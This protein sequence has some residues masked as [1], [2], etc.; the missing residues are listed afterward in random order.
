MLALGF[1]ISNEYIRRNRTLYI[2][3]ASSKYATVKIPGVG[4]FTNLKGRD[5]VP[6][7]EGRYQAVISG[8]VQQTVDFEISSGYWGRWFGDPVWVLNIG[9]ESILE[10]VHAHYRAEDP[11]P[12]DY[13]FLYGESFHRFPEVT[14]PFKELPKTISVDSGETRTLVNLEV[15]DGEPYTLFFY[16]NQQGRTEEAWRLAEWRLRLHPEDDAMLTHYISSVKKADQIE[17]VEKLLRFG[18]TNRPVLVQWHRFYQNLHQNKERDAA[19][20]G[21]VAE[22]DRMQAPGGFGIELGGL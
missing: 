4:E 21:P 10:L 12:P 20:A 1:V 19:L 17:R 6:I 18:L 16:F 8:P 22:R 7:K 5:G 3:N 9:G 2:V 13:T 14:H 15:F 11:Q